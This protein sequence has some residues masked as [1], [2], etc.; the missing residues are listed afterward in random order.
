MIGVISVDARVDKIYSAEK[1]DGMYIRKIS[2]SGKEVTRHG[3]FIRRVS[4]NQFVY[5]V[6]PFVDLVN[7]HTY[8]IYDSNYTAILNITD[9]I[10]N[11]ISLIA[12]YGYQY[13]NHTEDYWY[14]I[15]QIMIWRTVYPEGEF[16]FTDT[17]GGDNNINKYAKEIAEIESLVNNHYLT[18]E[19]EEI[20]V[21]QGDT[22]RFVDKNNVLSMYEVI[23]NTN[24]VIEGNELV[25]NG[26][27]IGIENIELRKNNDIYEEQP[28]VYSSDDSQK[29][30]SAGYIE[31]VSCMIN[32][33]VIGYTLKIIKVDALTGDTLKMA[34]IKFNIYDANTNEFIMEVMTDDNG[35]IIIDNL[36]KGSYKIKE[37]DNQEIPGYEINEK[38]IYFEIT[39]EE[40]IITVEFPNNP[41]LGALKVLKVNE[42]GNSLAGVTFGLYQSDG[43]L[44]DI[45]VTDESGIALFENLQ[46]G[47][48]QLKELATIDGYL[49]DETVHEIEL[50]LENNKLET[51]TIKLVNYQPKGSL[52]II[53]VDTNNNPLPETEFVLYDSN[54]KE[55]KK[56]KTNSEG[57]I[58]VDNLLLGKY[59]LE[60]ITPADGYKLLDDIIEFEINNNKEV[61]TITVTNEKIDIDIPD[62]EISM[63]IDD[64]IL[65]KRK[66]LLK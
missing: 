16:Y 66:N 1:I 40:E 22:K 52:E 37:I 6:E 64:Y 35:E 54:R 43:A 3:G 9:E 13:G 26:E 39:G 45:V 25:I 12:Y 58:I 28:L 11:R 20:K 63:N 14:Y 42:D 41:V 31:P 59:Y 56:A 21:N 30:L 49:L 8:D 19:F 51:V 33:E 48:Y 5:C 2:N 34:G 36:S 50:K 17:L 53:K 65:E 38:E 32:I 60:E 27:N 61:I 44:V 24:V 18:P 4:D 47:T 15:T 10:W 62:T 23:D 7:N 29:V 55:I 46:A 57:K